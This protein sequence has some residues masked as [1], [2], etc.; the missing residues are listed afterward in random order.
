MM[1]T[2][3]RFLCI[4]SGREVNVM[5]VMT[6]PVLHSASPLFLPY[7][8]VPGTL[9]RLL[10]VHAMAQVQNLIMLPMTPQP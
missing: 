3:T 7:N 5:Q 8:S 9:Q 4:A 10:D 2:S 1:M 6:Q